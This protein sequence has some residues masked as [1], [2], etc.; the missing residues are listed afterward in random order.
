MKWKGV[1]PRAGP[2]KTGSDVVEK[3][4]QARQL[5]KVDSLDRR[6][7]RKSIKDAVQ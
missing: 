7:W 2:K 1:R 5:C 3:D 6:K 4:C